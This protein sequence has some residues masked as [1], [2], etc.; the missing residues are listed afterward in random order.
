VVGRVLPPPPHGADWKRNSGSGQRGEA[1]K[2]NCIKPNT[3]GSTP[4][5][6]KGQHRPPTT[7][8]RP[9][10][11]SEDDWNARTNRR[12]IL[13]FST[14]IRNCPTVA[15]LPRSISRTLT[16]R[17]VTVRVIFRLG[18]KGCMGTVRRGS[19]STGR[20]T[21]R[22]DRHQNGGRRRKTET[23]PTPAVQEQRRP[24]SPHPKSRRR[25]T[26]NEREV[27]SHRR[28]IRTPTNSSETVPQRQACPG[29]LVRRLQNGWSPSGRSRLSLSGLGLR[30]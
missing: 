1:H 23:N 26:E 28:F 24:T 20:S 2:A 22:A 6:R 10:A 3:S 25:N 17:L 16:A 11:R 14:P 7:D 9:K 8:S 29:T 5:T 30:H 13:H 27:T 21:N 12:P 19:P 15:G 4:V 18:R